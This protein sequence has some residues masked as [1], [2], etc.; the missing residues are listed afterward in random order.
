MFYIITAL[1]TGATD[2]IGK[3]CAEFLAQ[4]GMDIVLISRTLS[5]LETVAAD[6]EANYKIRTKVI[7]ADFSNPSPEVYCKIEKELN[8]LRPLPIVL[9]NNVGMSYP[10][11]EYFCD[12]PEKDSMYMNI[13]CCNIVSVTNMTKLLLP[14]MQEEKKGVVINVSSTSALI[15]S[16]LLSVYAASKAYVHKLSKD[17]ATE[18]G[19][20][21]VLVQ[22]LAPGY[23]ATKMSKIKQSSWMAPSPEVYVQKALGTTGIQAVT[24]GYFPHSLL[25]GTVL[26]IESICPQFA[27]WLVVR[28]MENIR[29]RAL[30]RHAT[31]S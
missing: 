1:I 29:K 20:S 31:A 10:Y 18:Y 24:T 5:K 22:C 28:T 16:P 13:I 19:R 15:P 21:G 25:A 6:L 7:E 26:L 8:T 12:S 3:A 9:V 14:N 23:V 4:K 27:A 30:H 17:L 11:P 2:G